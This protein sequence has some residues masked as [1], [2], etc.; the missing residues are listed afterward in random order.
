MLA[1][2]PVDLRYSDAFI[3]VSDLLPEGVVNL[4]VEGFNLGGSIK[5]KAALHM[6]EWLER[7]N[8]LRPGMCVIES[9]SGNLGL[10]LS[11]VC[12]SKGYKFIC[13]SDPNLSPQSAQLMNAYGTQVIIVDK[14]DANGGF[15]G[16]RIALIQ[17]MLA[18][19][20]NLIWINQYANPENVGAH[21]RFTGPEILRQF[22]RPDYVFVGAGTTGTL[23]GVSR[24]LRERA[25]GVRII[26][27]DSV[28]SVT[29]GFPSGKRYIPGLGTSR[30]PE[31]ADPSSF[32]E[33]VMIPER[34]TILMCRHLARRGLLLGGSTGTVLCGVATFAQRIAKDAC[35]VALSPDF[36]DRYIDTIYNDRWVSER[37]PDLVRETNAGSVD[38][39]SVLQPARAAN[40][41]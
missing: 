37:F 2:S 32:D 10:A 29:F 41:R 19:D 26:A 39:L 25:P 30:T 18:Q 5:M 3:E 12:A 11:V 34:D 15:L 17:S 23:G 38:A 31:I 21:M 4:K 14:R 35:V 27:V 8:V 13:V 40:V 28:G 20:S 6:I 9:S 7:D 22:P 16:T 24:V 33:I 36:G 1:K